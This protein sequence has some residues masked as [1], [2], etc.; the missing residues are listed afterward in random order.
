MITQLPEEPTK[1]LLLVNQ[2]AFFPG[3]TFDPSGS[4]YT[5]V[6][7]FAHLLTLNQSQMVYYPQDAASVSDF[8]IGC[9][10]HLVQEGCLREISYLEAFLDIFRT[11][12]DAYVTEHGETERAAQAIYKTHPED[13]VTEYAS[14]NPAEDI[15]ESFVFFILESKPTGSTAADRKIAFFRS[16]PELVTLRIHMRNRLR[17]LTSTDN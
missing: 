16:Y 17:Q 1:R 9:Q 7:E 11:P 13:F 12:E 3:G 5:L 4:I 14:T 10:T 6:H 8:E 2:D 15:A